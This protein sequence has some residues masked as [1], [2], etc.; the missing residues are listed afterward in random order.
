MFPVLHV[1]H[2]H[3][4]LCQNILFNEPL[5]LFL[6]KESSILKDLWM[7]ASMPKYAKRNQLKERLQLTGSHPLL[8]NM[9]FL[10]STMPYQWAATQETLLPPSKPTERTKWQ[11]R[12]KVPQWSRHKFLY[13]RNCLQ[14]ISPLL[15]HNDQSV[16]K[17]NRS[18]SSCSVGW[19][20]PWIDRTTWLPLREVRFTWCLPRSTSMGTVTLTVRQTS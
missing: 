3:W 13:V 11:Q 10:Q 8:Q 14:S 15:Q 20:D 5:S 1:M 2:L 18:W 9:P 12:L 7:V 17:R 4:H 6:F 19:R 16:P